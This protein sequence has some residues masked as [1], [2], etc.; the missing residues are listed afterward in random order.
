[1]SIDKISGTSWSSISKVDGVSSANIDNIN[2]VAPPS[3]ATLLL[4]TYTGASLAYSFR[5]LNSSYS[6]YCIRIQNDSAVDLDVGF[7]GDYLDTSAIS[8]H[9]G[10]GNGRITIW[11]DQSGNGVN[12]TQ[13]SVS[14]MPTIY[15]S[16]SMLLVNSKA[17]ASFDG[18]DRLLT[19]STQVHTGSFYATSVI[20]TPASVAN[21]QILCQDDA[22]TPT[23][24]RVAQYLRTAASGTTGRS[25]VFNTSAAN[26]ADSSPSISG[27][28]QVQISSKATSTG[29]VE[30][31]ANSVSNGTTSYTGTL[32]TSS[33]EVSIGSN[34]HGATPAA[35]FTGSMQEIIVW[36]G[37]QS[38]NRASI[39]S[40]IDTYYS[41][42]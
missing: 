35:Y 29:S 10:G 30:C 39:E 11:Y 27:S 40:E 17:A 14:A 32:S 19:S 31:F 42:P 26:F 38:S 23:R 20:K 13:G 16:G 24:V 21:Q 8:S 7:S 18:G 37:D 25:V 36:D 33:H 12:A 9:C 6:G 28:T 34:T 3:G 41:I 22:N 4:D 1:M 5:K 2:S 15:S